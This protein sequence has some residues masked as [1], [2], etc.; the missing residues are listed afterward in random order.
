ML[1]EKTYVISW[2]K[3]MSRRRHNCHVDV[4]S[5]DD[6]DETTIAVGGVDVSK[7]V[8]LTEA[9]CVVVGRSSPGRSAKIRATIS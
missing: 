7:L 8:S 3:H 4:T 5:A 1:S 6:I 9:R 2:A